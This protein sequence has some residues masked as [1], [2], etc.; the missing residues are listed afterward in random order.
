MTNYHLKQLRQASFGGEG[1]LGEVVRKD[2]FMRSILYATV[3]D[4]Q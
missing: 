4:V 2:P 1:E 3:S